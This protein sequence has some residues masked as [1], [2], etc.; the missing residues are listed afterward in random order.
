MA[1]APQN[2]TRTVPHTL[3]RIGPRQQNLDIPTFRG[4]IHKWSAF[5]E[6]SEQT[7]DPN[8]ALP[9]TM[10][11][12]CLQHYLAAEAA[13]AISR[14]P[15]S[16]AC[17][18]NAVELLKEQLRDHKRIQQHHLSA[19]CDLLHVKSASDVIKLPRATL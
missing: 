2:T 18:A 5:R 15:T 19:L 16:K 17:Y 9:T 13:A 1:T 6:Q 3:T 10:K 11:V 14:F 7:I 12:F 8:N 4:N